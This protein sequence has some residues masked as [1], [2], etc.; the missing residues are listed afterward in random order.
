MPIFEYRCQDCGN[1]FEVIS[2][3]DQTPECPQ[4]QTQNLQRELS[5]F[6]VG[7]KSSSSSV[8]GCGAQNCCMGRGGCSN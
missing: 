5:T 4:C 8:T 6:A 2:F 1:K 3:G 7:A